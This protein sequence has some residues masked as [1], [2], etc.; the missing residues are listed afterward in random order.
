MEPKHH[1][2]NH[3]H[4]LSSQR[5]AAANIVRSQIENILKNP[6]ASDTNPYHR[7]HQTS[8]STTSS[9]EEY[10]S[11]WQ[12]YYKKYYEGYYRHYLVDEAKEKSKPELTDSDRV[13]TLRTE[14]R[15]KMRSKATKVKKSRHFK[16]I[17]TGLIVAATLLLIQYGRVIV[18]NAYAFVSP[19]SINPQ[20]IVIN[21]LT[22]LAVSPEPRLVIPKIN[23]DVPVIYDVGNDYDS[24]MAAMAEGV[25]H[26]A[27]PGASSHPGEVG[28]TVLSGHSANGV[29]DTSAYKFIFAGLDKLTVGDVLYAHYKGTRYTY[30]VTKK[31]VV[32][33]DDVAKLVYPTTKPLLTLVTC[34][35]LGTSKYRLLVT[36]EQ[37]SPD[38]AKALASSGTANKDQTLPGNSP[39]FFEWLFSWL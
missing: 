20:N 14:I 6:T 9:P 25:S 13:K 28:N 3:P 7:T 32:N 1:K 30:S 15:S 21:P 24:Q 31:E 8:G 39:T 2:V 29:F 33:P 38:P 17:L 27:V 12:E 11:A 36:A 35:P 23:V 4:K 22:D 19:G 10:H 37:I 34:T 5:D 18:A 26:F 16:P